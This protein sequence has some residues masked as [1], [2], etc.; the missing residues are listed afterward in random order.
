ME[1]GRVQLL[2]C[3]IYTRGGLEQGVNSLRV[4]RKSSE[5]FPRASTAKAGAWS[6]TAYDGG[7]I[8]QPERWRVFVIFLRGVGGCS[9]ERLTYGIEHRAPARSAYTRERWRTRARL[10]RLLTDLAERED[11]SCGSVGSG[12]CAQGLSHLSW[13]ARRPPNVHRRRAAI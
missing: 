1:R 11:E 12:S 8:L 7:Q 13:A 4:L 3:A 9:R 10:R 2:S 5:A 6:R